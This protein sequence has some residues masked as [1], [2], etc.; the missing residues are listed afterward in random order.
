MK[1]SQYVASRKLE[2]IQQIEK[3]RIIDFFLSKFHFHTHPHAHTQIDRSR[4]QMEILGGARRK[5]ISVGV[6]SV[7]QCSVCLWLWISAGVQSVHPGYKGPSVRGPGWADGGRHGRHLPRRGLVLKRPPSRTVI[8]SKNVKQ[9]F[10]TRAETM[11]ESRKRK[12]KASRKKKKKTR[13]PAMPHDDTRETFIQVKKIER[14]VRG[15]VDDKN[16]NGNKIPKR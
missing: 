11:K 10:S 6:P 7:Q 1:G 9:K 16:L 8:D 14:R 3:E 2:G 4:R 15:C 13:H 5:S 12:S